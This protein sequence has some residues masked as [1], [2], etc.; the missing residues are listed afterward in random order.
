M[1][2]FISLLTF[3]IFLNITPS[4]ARGI[5]Q[6]GVLAPPSVSTEPAHDFCN[7]YPRR[8]AYIEDYYNLKARLLER[9]YKYNDARE[10]ALKV[11]EAGTKDRWVYRPKLLPTKNSEKEQSQKIVT[12][13]TALQ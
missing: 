13:G 3:L 5:V 10:R 9:A 6:C 4:N 11:Y 1:R 12:F 8:S 7:I 2:Q